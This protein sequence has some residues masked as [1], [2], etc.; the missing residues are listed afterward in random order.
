[1]DSDQVFSSYWQFANANTGCVCTASVEGWS[2]S[3]LHSFG[4]A[5]DGANPDFE[6]LVFDP[7]G[8]AYGTTDFGGNCCSAGGGTVFKI[9]P[10]GNESILYRFQGL[11]DGSL[12]YGG[13]VRDSLGN[14]YGTT[15]WS[16]TSGMG[17]V[18]K[19]MPSGI[20][21][22]MENVLHSFTGGPDGGFHTPV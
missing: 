17:I 9:A 5:P 22:R 1:M 12:P 6:S 2:F 7:S 20:V 14:L 4:G 11:T 15:Y 18:F 19:A 21:A 10:D 3:L 16:G 8:N 13:L